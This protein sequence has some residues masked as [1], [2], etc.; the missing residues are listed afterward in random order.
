ML[1]ARPPHA[2]LFASVSQMTMGTRPLDGCDPDGSSQYR[3]PSKHLSNAAQAPELVSYLGRMVRLLL[4]LLLASQPGND[5]M[6]WWLCDDGVSRPGCA[7]VSTFFRWVTGLLMM[8]L[9]E[10]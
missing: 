5:C 7:Q 6:Q 4:H 9:R 2:F 10:V 3:N 1:L 8:A